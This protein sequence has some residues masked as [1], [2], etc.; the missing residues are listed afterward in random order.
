M[1]EKDSEQ[2][3]ILKNITR[4]LQELANQSGNIIKSYSISKDEYNEIIKASIDA[5]NSQSNK[6]IAIKDKLLDYNKSNTDD[7]LRAIYD[8]LDDIQA[9]YTAKSISNTEFEVDEPE[10]ETEKHISML[11]DKGM[12][13][14]N[15]RIISSLMEYVDF[16]H[17]LDL[18]Y[19]SRGQENCDWPLLPSALRTE[20]SGNRI[21]SNEDIQEMVNE[22]HKTLAYYDKSYSNQ[23]NELE[24]LAYAQHF[25]IP[26]NLID[27]TE[28]HL[29]SL[30]FALE[31]YKSDFCA[32][33]YFVDAKSFNVQKCGKNT[34]PNCSDQKEACDGGASSIFIKSDNVNERIH[35]QKGYF[36]KTPIN[37]DRDDAIKEIKDFCKVVLIPPDCKYDVLQDLF[38]LGLGFQSIYPD[39]DNMAKTIKFK[40]RMSHEV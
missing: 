30:L 2:I 31:N 28:S 18:G 10:N 1:N 19:L 38:K 11:C 39:L 20:K 3:D 29:I 9:E 13:K 6:I 14:D 27:F 34:I 16:V 35:F 33:V 24:I 25:S 37:Y 15:I 8:E 23:K 32:I 21:Y 36:L 12:K 40:N 4:A 17:E 26:T 22:F 5:F 7:K